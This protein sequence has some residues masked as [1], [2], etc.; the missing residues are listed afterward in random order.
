MNDEQMRY[1]QV[2]K[3]DAYPASVHPDI[4]QGMPR[5]TNA[6]IVALRALVR[7]REALYEGL[8][9]LAWPEIRATET[10]I[11]EILRNE[12]L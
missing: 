9:P 2:K 8:E 10:S 5:Y 7:Q 1:P 6:N 12:F 11:W 4:N 3:S